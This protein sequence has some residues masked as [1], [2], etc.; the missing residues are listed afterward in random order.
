VSRAH[1][2]I[3]EVDVLVTDPVGNEVSVSQLIHILLSQVAWRDPR[4]DIPQ[5][6]YTPFAIRFAS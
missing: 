5:D 1:V 2:I 3:R 4:F 6:G